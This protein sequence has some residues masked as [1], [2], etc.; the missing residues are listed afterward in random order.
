MPL[1]LDAPAVDEPVAAQAGRFKKLFQSIPA[2]G[3]GYE[4]L[5]LEDKVPAAHLLCP[6]RFNYQPLAGSGFAG[7]PVGHDLWQPPGH[8]RTYAIDWVVKDLGDEL[9]VRVRYSSGRLH[10]A[11]VERQVAAW[12]EAVNFLVE[13]WTP[14]ERETPA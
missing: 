1:R 4:L 11:T 14:S 7:A 6:V 2:G 10:A 8:V 12:R 5:A 3:T 13:Q 9:D